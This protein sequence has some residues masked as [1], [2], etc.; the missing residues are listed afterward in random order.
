MTICGDNLVTSVVTVCGDSL[1]G[2]C[3]GRVTVETVGLTVGLTARL[4][5]SGLDSGV[6]GGDSWRVTVV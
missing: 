1:G 6:D 3:G 5:V 4:T 2:I